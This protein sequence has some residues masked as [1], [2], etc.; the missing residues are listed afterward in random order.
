M[1]KLMLN[2]PNKSKLVLYK[3]L[4]HINSHLKQ[5]YIHIYVNVMCIFDLLVF[6]KTV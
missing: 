3:A 4:I 1:T 2:Q 6:L 5:L